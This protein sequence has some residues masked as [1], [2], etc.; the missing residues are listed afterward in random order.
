MKIV[1]AASEF[2]PYAK[3]GGLADVAGA[4]PKALKPLGVRVRTLIPGYPSV[5]AHLDQTRTVRSLADFYGGPARLLSATVAGLELYVLDAPH[6]YDRS[7]GPYAGQDGLDFPDNPRRFAALARM[8]ASIG[9]GL[10]PRYRP[11]IIH[12]HDWQAALAPAFLQYDGGP[13]PA[14][15]CTIHNLGWSI[16]ATSAS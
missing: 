6:L 4:L 8:G 12:V 9:Q 3:T 1:H 14:T 5:M 15:V 7:G 2:F 13:R 11:Q 10:V 16:T